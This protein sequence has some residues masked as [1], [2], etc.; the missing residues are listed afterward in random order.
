MAYQ[1]SNPS[2]KANEVVKPSD[3][4]GTKAA[5][6][7]LSNL[8][9][10]QNKRDNIATGY[11]SAC[12]QNPMLARCDPATSF[13]AYL[14]GEA[15]GFSFGTGEYSIVP[16]KNN[17]RGGVYEAQFMIGY[18]GYRQLALR[19]R[20]YQTVN[21]RVVREGEYK[22]RSKWTGEPKIEFKEFEE[23]DKPVVGY[24]AY[25]VRVGE[26]IPC[27]SFYMTKEEAVAWRKKYSKS[28]PGGVWETN[29]DAMALKTVIK[30]L[31]DKQL[32]K[33]TVMANAIKYDQSVVIASED[34]KTADI[35][36]PDN[37]ENE[38]S[39]VYEEEAAAEPANQ[40]EISPADFL[41]QP[42]SNL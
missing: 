28:K 13:P 12:A 32:E 33:S 21:A 20:A 37:P 5:K 18:K 7:M 22:G 34:K 2:Q 29:F 3:F 15:L 25:A 4:I 9:S 31:C 10:D 17:N 24:F 41:G 11:L 27:Q 40:D 26:E 8:F 16:F 1:V 38:E 39:D 6:N 19:S 14:R 35:I 30:Q 42:D 23:L 36:Y